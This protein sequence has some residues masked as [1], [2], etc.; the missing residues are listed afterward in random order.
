MNVPGVV[1]ENWNLELLSRSSDI[2]AL[3]QRAPRLFHDRPATA[4]PR[5]FLASVTRSVWIPRVVVVKRGDEIEGVVYAK[6]RKFAGLATGVLFGHS[7]P[8]TLVVASPDRDEAVL[9]QALRFLLAERRF[10]GIRI[11]VPAHGFEI[12]V[13]Q[14][15]AV[16]CRAEFSQ[17]EDSYHHVVPLSLDY[18]RFLTSLSAKFRRNMRY[19]RRRYE[20]AGHHYVENMDLAEFRRVAFRILDRS[21]VGGSREGVI[22]ALSIFSEVDRPLLVGLRHRDGEWVAILGG[23]CED[24]RP[25]VFFQM[26]NDRDYSADSLSVVLRGYF[27]ETLIAQGHREV[28]FWAGVG[29]P[30][31]R[32]AV[33]YPSFRACVDAHTL[34]WRATRSLVKALAPVLPQRLHSAMDWIAP[35]SGQW[36]D[37]DVQELA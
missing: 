26:N 23:W 2:A 36:C 12:R 29:G 10:Q 13:M 31:A 20:A 24:D 34:R 16:R 30:L 1:A 37:V 19:Y 11:L 15:A 22:R 8:G 27:L 33:A 9:E 17:F 18:E 7:T 4:G 32:G 25:I 35:S 5:F 28:F 21:V 14:R 3:A 6:E